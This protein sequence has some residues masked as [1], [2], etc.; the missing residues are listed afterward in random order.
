MSSKSIISTKICSHLT[1]GNG[2]PP[3]RQEPSAR[4]REGCVS[5]RATVQR[6]LADP[7]RA[8]RRRRVGL[9]RAPMRPRP[10]AGAAAARP[11]RSPASRAPRRRWRSARRR[12]GRRSGRIRRETRRRNNRRRRSRRPAVTAIAARCARA[13]RRSPRAPRLAELHHDQPRAEPEIEVGDC[14]RVGRGRQSS[15]ASSR[16]GRAM[17]DDRIASWMTARA[18]LSGQSFR[19]RFGS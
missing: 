4:L 8:R 17:S 14:V 6:R 16:P 13:A 5:R 12:T 10:P 2:A 1:R 19:R 11:R 18:R 9:R 3:W 15:C 7:R